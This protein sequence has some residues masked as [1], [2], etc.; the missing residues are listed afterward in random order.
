MST[1]TR[2]FVVVVSSMTSIPFYEEM[3]M[4]IKI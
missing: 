3:V 4:N 1:N 2:V